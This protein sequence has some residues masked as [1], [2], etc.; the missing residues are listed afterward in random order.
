MGPSGPT[1]AGGILS[2]AVT[3]KP[4]NNT[5]STTPVTQPARTDAKPAGTGVAQVPPGAI[6]AADIITSAIEE[7]GRKGIRPPRRRSLRDELNDYIKPR[8]G[9]PSILLAAP[10]IETLT[11]IAGGIADL[12]WSD[13]LRTLASAVITDEIARR[14][15]L[16]NR[17][18]HSIAA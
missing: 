6:D 4:T 5:T 15:A 12:D 16:I 9:D 18:H 14:R 2:V 8:A 13:Q 10:A 3:P 7:T 11:E 1:R 17:R